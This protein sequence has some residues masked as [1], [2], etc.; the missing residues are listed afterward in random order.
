MDAVV[1]AIGAAMDAA[2]AE[3]AGRI[4]PRLR[5]PPGPSEPREPAGSPAAA[6]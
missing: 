5:A 4:V 3:L 1:A 6:R 2:S